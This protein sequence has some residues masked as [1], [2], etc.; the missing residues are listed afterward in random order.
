MQQIT[1][2][3]NS[4]IKIINAKEEVYTG[5]INYNTTRQGWFLD[6]VGENFKIY[7]IRITTCPNILRQWSSRLGFGIGILC[8]QKGEPF[9]WEDFNTERA[10]MYLLEPADLEYQEI[11]YAQ[12]Q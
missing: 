6:L 9:F 7:G 10:K 11:L 4:T 3:E 5:Y 2:T 1:I 12:I 8:E